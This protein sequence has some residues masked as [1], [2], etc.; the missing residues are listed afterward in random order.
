MKKTRGS[1]LTAL[2]AAGLAAGLAMVPGAF[3]TSRVFAAASSSNATPQSGTSTATTPE[4]AGVQE[5]D[6]SLSIGYQKKVIQVGETNGV[7]LSIY[8]SNISNSDIISLNWYMEDPDIA[9]FQGTPTSTDRKVT[10]VGKKNGGTNACADVTYMFLGEQRSQ[11]LKCSIYV[12]EMTSN[13]DLIEPG[14]FQV[15]STGD[16]TLKVNMPEQVDSIDELQWSITDTSIADFARTPGLKDQTVT[17]KG[18]KAGTSHIYVRVVF[19]GGDH[20]RYGT[21]VNVDEAPANTSSGSG[22]SDSST[23]SGDSTDTSTS[24]VGGGGSSGGGGGSS[25]G[26]GSNSNR[27]NTAAHA[28]APLPAVTPITTDNSGIVHFGNTVIAQPPARF[29]EYD[30]TLLITTGTWTMNSLGYWQLKGTNAGDLKGRWALVSDSLSQNPAGNA[31][32]FYFDS[33]GYVASGWRWIA[34]A[35]GKYRCYY[36]NQ[37][38]GSLFGACLLNGT[39]PDGYTVDENGA[40]TENGV[41]VTR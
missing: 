28:A 15:N 3:P 37:E 12:G 8:D 39:T 33:N 17:L 16:F 7:R 10:V 23:N 22:N 41:V 27:T 26:G 30:R 4:D 24:T 32:W 36:F 35:D 13:F 38:E 19:N 21:S 34:G 9:D 14:H 6:R 29:T 25:S 18:L 1:L 5:M 31:S 2:A 11:T 20:E 40:W